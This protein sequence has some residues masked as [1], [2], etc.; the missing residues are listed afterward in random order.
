MKTI[1]AVARYFPDKCGG[2]QIRLSELLPVLKDDGIESKIAAAREGS[3]QEETYDYN[4][5]EVYRYPVLS[6][7][8]LEPNH[9]EIPHAGFAYFASWLKEQ[10]ANIYHQHQWTPTCGLAHLRLAKELGMATLVSIR[11][12]QPICLRQ[13]LMLNG[14]EACDGIIDEVR[15]TRCCDDFSKNIP[16]SALKAFSH[17]PI[18]VLSRIPM[19]KS[20]YEPTSIANTKGVLFRPL[21]VP[22]FVTAR[23]NS[24]LEMAKYA[25]R[26]VTLSE[27]IYQMLL[28]NGIPP[29]KAIIC[30]T[31]IPD[32]FPQAT[33]KLNDRTGL[34]RVVF[35]G[36]W[37]RTKGIHILVEAIQSLP[38]DIP[39]ELTIHGIATDEDYRQ[40]ILNKIANDPRIKVDRALS[41]SELP[42][43]LASFDVLALPAQWFDVRPMVVLEAH[44][45]GLPVIGS[46]MGGI[47][48]LI[49]HNIDGLLVPPTDVKAWAQAMAKL[50]TDPYL[51]NKLRQGISP[52]RT[53]SMEAADTAAIYNHL[54]GDRSP[55]KALVLAAH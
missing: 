21:A 11:L 33:P 37:N 39:I 55:Q 10:K 40:E 28:A 16:A 44:A 20:V 9:G 13:T 50:A 52:L 38:A 5:I 35:L 45:S 23:R 17:I 2:I 18:S 14:E 43:V 46:D 7:P 12:P 6:R 32:S 49:G 51:L 31:G 22:A 36:R 27:R 30:R 8:K 24:L 29:E 48:E 41:R 25:D 47:P 54:V 19:P 34:L 42:A 4:G 26:I 1:Q 15:C 53:M 3:Q